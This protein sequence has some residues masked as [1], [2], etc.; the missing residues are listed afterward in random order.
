MNGTRYLAC[1]AVFLA[2]GMTV[3]YEWGLCAALIGAAVLAV[4]AGAVCALS[5]KKSC[6]GFFCAAFLLLAAGSVRMDAEQRDWTGQSHY[7]MGHTVMVEA[8]IAGEPVVKAGE[9]GYIRY[10]AEMRKAVFPDGAEKKAY[11]SLY[12][13]RPPGEVLPAGSAIRASGKIEPVRLY[14]NPGKIDLSGRYEDNRIIG[15]IY[16]KTENDVQLTGR[17][18]GYG[19]VRKAGE[20][21]DRL[22]EAFRPYMD[23]QRL[24][25]LMTLLFGGHY[26]E[27]AADVVKS[28]TDTGI[29]H[30]LS[31][32]GSHISLLFGFLYMLGRWMRIPPKWVFPGAVVFVLFYAGLAG[33]VPPVVRSVIMGILSAGGTVLRRD[34]EAVNLLGAAV[35]GML[36]WDPLYICD[37]SFQLSVGASAGI[38]LF[39][40]PALDW[41]KACTP[42]PKRVREGTAI[43]FSAQVLLIPVILYNFHSIPFYAAAANLLV[44]PML[45]CV[46]IMGLAASL[47]IWIVPFLGG[48]VLT[49]ADVLLW[50]AV[51]MNL[52]IAQLPGARVQM[53][54]FSAAETVL[55]YTGAAALRAPLPYLGS[56]GRYAVCGAAAAAMIA[57]SAWNGLHRPVM[58]VI[59]PDLGQC[60]ALIICTPHR[61]IL[62][63]RHGSVPVDMGERELRSLLEYEG[64]FSLDVLIMDVRGMTDPV[65]FTL[66]MP[67]GKIL[68]SGSQYQ[69]LCATLLQDA[70]CPRDEAKDG[71]EWQGADMELYCRGGSWY[72]ASG[73]AGVYIDG[74]G[75]LMK[76]WEKIRRPHT[77]WAGGADASGSGAEEK[78]LQRID[79][80]GAVYVAPRT[81]GAGEEK[82]LFHLFGWPLYSPDREG[83]VKALC[84]G[85]GWSA[86][87]MTGKN[88]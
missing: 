15:R 62:Y 67:I 44:T 50:G 41:M 43:T 78:K 9:D 48:A 42:L 70:S 12:I 75:P 3:D 86:S 57:C 30:I 51:H 26:D 71:M 18:E 28:F 56:W 64:I 7:L 54:G 16:T 35:T 72:A 88:Q 29:I 17:T 58:T 37:I 61:N 40:R 73:D 45:E 68:F 79:P 19:A 6:A 80:E 5:G 8:V 27:I 38:L 55:Y 74:C 11:G 84:G 1:A 63:Y 69:T 66:H 85:R 25:L 87:S 24:P 59:A 31:V 53:R 39:T 76:D 49:A 36:L 65:P 52:W 20:I 34:K 83:M 32:S 46:I 2:F 14:K 77:F 22:E 47:L 10:C 33:F 21:K 81:V 13:Y 23:G 82:E 60:R 4:P